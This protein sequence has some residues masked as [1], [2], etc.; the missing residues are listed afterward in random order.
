MIPK[1]LNL[2]ALVAT[3]IKTDPDNFDEINAQ[4]EKYEAAK[5]E[6]RT[7][8][9]DHDMAH[10][11]VVTAL[12]E[13]VLAARTARPDFDPE[14]LIADQDEARAE[15]GGSGSSTSAETAEELVEGN[16]RE[17]LV[18]L[19]AKEGVDIDGATTKADIAARIVATR[20][21]G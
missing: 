6:L 18:A 3:L 1:L 5:A 10:A 4:I 20:S 14:A 17:A 16:T 21:A 19:A 8:H 11:D 9:G 12:D 7:M 13:A 15:S 2:I